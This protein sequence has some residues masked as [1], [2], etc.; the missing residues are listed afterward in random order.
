MTNLTTAAMLLKEF[1]ASL[2][3]E[4]L[5]FV[6]NRCDLMFDDIAVTLELLANGEFIHIYSYLY[7]IPD[8]KV[9]DI[10]LLLLDANYLFSAT[11]GSTF[12]MDQESKKVVLIR[13]VD[14]SKTTLAEFEILIES[15]IN[16]SEQWQEK[17]TDLC[18]QTKLENE[19]PKAESDDFVKV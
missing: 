18:N 4:G 3:I 11:A 14:V 6:D 10:A 9:A 13:E 12:G 8:D 2:R 15:F 7:T 17:I 16:L 1:G 19:Q 5:I